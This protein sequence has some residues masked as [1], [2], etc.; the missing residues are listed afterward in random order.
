MQLKMIQCK[1]RTE[2]G[3]DY[4]KTNLKEKDI[5]G[6]CSVGL[7]SFNNAEANDLLLRPQISVKNS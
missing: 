2:A 5:K 1:Q 4:L 6:T 3:N 7:H